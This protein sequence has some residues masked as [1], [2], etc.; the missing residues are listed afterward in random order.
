[1]GV[2]TPCLS[3]AEGNPELAFGEGPHVRKTTT[4]QDAVAKKPSQF[5]PVLFGVERHPQRLPVDGVATVEAIPES[6]SEECID[7]AAGAE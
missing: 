5:A 6:I 7:A 1:M 2:E 4:R 3:L